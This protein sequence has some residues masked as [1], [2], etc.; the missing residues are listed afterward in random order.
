[1]NPETHRQTTE[2]ALRHLEAQGF[3]VKPLWRDL[4]ARVATH[5]RGTPSADDVRY[6]LPSAAPSV[7]DHFTNG[8]A[9]LLEPSALWQGYS[10]ELS[11]SQRAIL[12]ETYG[13]TPTQTVTVE[14]VEVWP[15]TQHP[16]AMCLRSDMHVDPR[17]RRHVL[18]RAVIRE[19][20]TF[21]R[22]AAERDSEEHVKHASSVVPEALTVGR[23][24]T[25][26]AD[27]R[28]AVEDITGVKVTSKVE[29]KAVNDTTFSVMCLKSGNL[30]RVPRAEF[31]ATVAEYAKLHAEDR[32]PIRGRSGD[33]TPSLDALIN[34]LGL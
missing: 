22:T 8:R 19:V 21:F 3:D 1:M 20:G 23:V 6:V 14:W 29:V 17:N 12:R 13:L 30:A 34:S 4:S 7:A 26:E 31:F 16:R 28:W 27:D 33:P 10:Y 5:E 24:L 2:A 32:A 11:P 15:G 25:L 9:Q 18:S